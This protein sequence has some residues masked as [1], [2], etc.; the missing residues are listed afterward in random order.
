MSGRRFVSQDGRFGLVLSESV[1]QEVFSLCARAGSKE[2]GGILVGRYS[3]S[4]NAAIVTKASPPPPDS[5]SGWNWFTRGVR[6]LQ[7]WLDS[8]WREPDR[9]YYLGEWHFHPGAAPVAS[10][11]DAR[12]M[13]AIA[14]DPKYNCP[15]PVLLIIGG[16]PTKRTAGAYVAVRGNGLIE[17]LE[18]VPEAAP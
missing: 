3:E 14:A 15:E 6:G 11:T 7:R 16:T 9:S 17:L 8:L 12:Q 18:S 4:N 1:V 13:E 2:T 10:D 5:R